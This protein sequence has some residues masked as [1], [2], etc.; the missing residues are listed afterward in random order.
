MPDWS[1]LNNISLQKNDNEMMETQQQMCNGLFCRIHS[2]S[3]VHF[4][5]SLQMVACDTLAFSQVVSKQ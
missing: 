1:Q 4:S 3:L 2:Y 5:E